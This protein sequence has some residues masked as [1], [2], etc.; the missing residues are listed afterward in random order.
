MAQFMQ[1]KTITCLL[2]LTTLYIS[3]YAYC[4]II[5]KTKAGH[6]Y[7][8]MLISLSTHLT[9]HTLHLTF[10]RLCCYCCHPLINDLI[11]PTWG[12]NFSFNNNKS[13]NKYKNTRKSKKQRQILSTSGGQA[14]KS[15]HRVGTLNLLFWNG[16]WKNTGINRHVCAR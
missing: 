14:G 11:S 16:A 5:W 2:K 10:V 3:L 8:V 1:D 6:F 4:S 15:S 9:R 13:L 12:W 7:S